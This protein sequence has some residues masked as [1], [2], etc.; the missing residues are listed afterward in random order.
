MELISYCINDV[1]ICMSLR[2]YWNIGL[3]IYRHVHWAL[4]ILFS[5]IFCSRIIKIVDIVNRFV[6]FTKQ[7]SFCFVNNTTSLRDEIPISDRCSLTLHRS[8]ADALRQERARAC[9]C[10]AFISAADDCPTDVAEDWT[11]NWML[12]EISDNGIELELI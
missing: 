2:W 3:W 6:L 11:A 4:Q 9:S 5:F 7:N 10:S 1:R 12:S 8:D